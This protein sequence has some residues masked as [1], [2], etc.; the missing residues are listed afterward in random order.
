MRVSSNIGVAGVGVIEPARMRIR[1]DRND[2]V[3]RRPRLVCSAPVGAEQVV[4]RLIC[5]RG[6]RLAARPS[7]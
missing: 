6:C 7:L 3:R 2:S 1:R 4:L 5:V